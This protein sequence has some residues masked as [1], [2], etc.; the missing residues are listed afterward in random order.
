MIVMKVGAEHDVNGIDRHPGL[1]K[2][3]QK[4]PVQAIEIG[5]RPS[6]LLPVP[7]STSTVR[8]STLTTQLWLGHWKVIDSSPRK[9]CGN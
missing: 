6:R 5:P 8:P 9:P 7:G 1:G 3:L 4:R 2:S